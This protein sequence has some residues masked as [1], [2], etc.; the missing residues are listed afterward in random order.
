MKTRFEAK[1]ELVLMGLAD[2]IDQH[3]RET[4]IENKLYAFLEFLNRHA[5][6]QKF[7]IGQ[8][9]DATC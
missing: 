2:S 5:W 1:R 3:E 7:K 4:D 9:E 8:P 6:R